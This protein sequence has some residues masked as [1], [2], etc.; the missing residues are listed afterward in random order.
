MKYNH[1]K[2]RILSWDSYTSQQEYRQFT[3]AGVVGKE[4][5]SGF[6]HQLLLFPLRKKHN[7]NKQVNYTC[8]RTDKP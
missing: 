4:F 7:N 5:L 8:K 2:V 6:S 1:K 3:K